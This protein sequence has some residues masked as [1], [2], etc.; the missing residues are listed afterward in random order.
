[1]RRFLLALFCTTLCFYPNFTAQTFSIRSYTSHDGL[2]ND[3]ILS[4]QQDYMGR[5]WIGTPHGLC[6]FDGAEYTFYT[7]NQ[8]PQAHISNNIV[9][10][11]LPRPNGDVWFGTPDS[12]NIYSWKD[13]KIHAYGK[14]KGLKSKDI[15]ALANGYNGSIWV[16]TFG[17]GIFKYDEKKGA[18]STISA[19]ARQHGTE[20]I[21][22]LCEDFKHQLWIGTRY[23]GLFLYNPNTNKCIQING[24]STIDFV[25]TIYQDRSG[26]I[27]VGT[28]NNFYHIVNNEAKPMNQQIFANKHNRRKS[29]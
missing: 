26:N 27:W 3:K 19:I 1:M 11:I 23:N 25:R 15:T 16:G 18:F 22:A 29:Q 8:G 24:I 28:D 9:Q 14:V 7:K 6:C 2:M 17:E 20:T 12:L 10:T 4:I 21:M 5:M 13:D